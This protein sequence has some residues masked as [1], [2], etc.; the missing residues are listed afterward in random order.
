[1]STPAKI[2]AAAAALAAVILTGFAGTASP[3]VADDSVSA[4]VVFNLSRTTLSDG[5]LVGSAGGTSSTL[6]PAPASGATAFTLSAPKSES[7]SRTLIYQLGMV[8]HTTGYWV[9][10]SIQYYTRGVWDSSCSIYKGRPG[11]AGAEAATQWNCQAPSSSHDAKN[12]AVFTISQNRFAEASGTL[13]TTGAVSLT[14]G[15]YDFNNL[16]YAH[17]G[18]PKLGE[19]A[20]TKFAVVMREGDT[21]ISHGALA[22]A[23]FSYRILDGGRPTNYW[24]VGW[25]QTERGAIFHHHAACFVTSQQPGKGSVPLDELRRDEVTPYDCKVAR[26]DTVNGDR[27]TYDAELVVGDRN[28]TVVT[29]AASAADLV[30]RFCTSIDSQDCTV[31]LTNAK[32][33]TK[34]LDDKLKYSFA[35]YTKHV[36]KPDVIIEEKIVMSHKYGLEITVRTDAKILGQKFGVAVK[37]K[38]EFQWKEEKTFEAKMPVDVEPGEVSWVQVSMPLIV[39]DGDVLIFDRAKNVT[40]RLPNVHV[41]LPDDRKNVQWAIKSD[42]LAN[43]PHLSP[44]TEV[45][46]PD[47]TTKTAPSPSATPT[48]APTPTG[49]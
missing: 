45:L 12:R 38:Y 44:D 36:W 14:D 3:A 22:R 10:A 48:P 34:P 15:E 11:S 13:R 43:F 46:N 19:N 23:R 16:P 29:N 25:S 47:N 18:S 27:G 31:N 4:Q 39:A 42:K 17:P 8:G 26:E 41:E 32:Q 7:M 28:M 37:N 5:Q 1:M 24:V 21:T 35:N 30:S 49:K 9:K 33:T 6:V 2:A 20:N 40:Y